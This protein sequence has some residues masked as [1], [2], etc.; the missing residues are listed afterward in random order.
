MF[1]ISEG[2]Q[3]GEMG[4]TVIRS[5]TQQAVSAG[6]VAAGCWGSTGN[7]PQQAGEAAAVHF[8]AS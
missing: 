1:V 5:P 3:N 6:S 2:L 7:Q 8:V 4:F